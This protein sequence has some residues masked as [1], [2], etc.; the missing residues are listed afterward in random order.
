MNRA[1]ENAKSARRSRSASSIVESREGAKRS[2]EL[3]IAMNSPSARCKP[4]VDRRVRAFVALMDDRD[5]VRRAMRGEL[6]D[7]RARRIARSV[8]DNDD[9]DV[10]KRLRDDRIERLPYEALVVVRRHDD[11]HAWRHALGARDG[12]P[13]RFSW[14]GRRR[15]RQRGQRPSPTSDA[16]APQSGA[17][18]GRCVSLPGKRGRNGGPARDD[19]L[20][21]T[22]SMR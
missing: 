12:R 9:L 14:S 10:A 8:V 19:S 6:I 11:R 21:P 5:G 1:P 3:M 16:P 20:R 13:K 18:R 4:A 22:R 15:A 2:S 17:Q 7:Q